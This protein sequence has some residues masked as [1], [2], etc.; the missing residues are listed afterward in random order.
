MSPA[1]NEEHRSSKTFLIMDVFEGLEW[2]VY[3]HQLLPSYHDS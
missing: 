1:V 2:G 3:R